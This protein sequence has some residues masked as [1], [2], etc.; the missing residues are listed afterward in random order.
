MIAPR[1]LRAR[2]LGRKRTAVACALVAIVCLAS[3]SAADEV[4][5]GKTVLL[6]Y[7]ESRL[8]PSIVAADEAI[9]ETLTAR[10]PR[11]ITFHTEYLESLAELHGASFEPE[12]ARL[13]RKKY[14]HAKPDVIIA[15]RGAAHFVLARRSE[16]FP[17]VPI[18]LIGLGRASLRTREVDPGITGVF[19]AP[20]WAPTLD[21]ALALHPATRRVMVVHGGSPIDREWAARARQELAPYERR[22]EVRHVTALS[23]DKLLAE[24]ARLPD[25]TLVFVGSVLTDAGGRRLG[26]RRVV[27]QLATVSPRPVYGLLELV[28]GDGIV[29]GRLLVPAAHGVKAAE[30][31]LRMLDGERLGL[32][33]GVE[34]VGSAYMFDARQLARWGI[35][36][37]ALPAGSIVRFREPSLWTLYRWQLIGGL[38]VVAL[39]TALIAG[40]LVERR[41]RRV[42]QQA[43]DARLRF[44]H[45][46]ADLTATF[47]R[48]RPSEVEPAIDQALARVIDVLDVDRA[49]LAEFASDERSIRLTHRQRRPGLAPISPDVPMQHYPWT[50]ARMLRGECVT[51]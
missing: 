22:V 16:V 50:V 43:L 42:A 49:A 38:S 12:L 37:A 35:S 46:L 33:D 10:S 40:L 23:L 2:A 31:A 26:A 11:P 24:A 41:R 48:L 25:G 7:G 14:A 36:E 13:L 15:G 9:R 17:G 30:L 45:L 32:G 34:N 29:G 47:A 5:E 28:L 19:A 18:V 3:A 1:S 39:E 20:E 51:F 27:Q 6:L 21:V 44:E 4:A 8:L